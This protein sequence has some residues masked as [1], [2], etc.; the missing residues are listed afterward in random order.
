MSDQRLVL[1]QDTS[2]WLRNFL[3]KV[4]LSIKEHH[5]S[6]TLFM[7]SFYAILVRLV[8]SHE[9]RNTTCLPVFVWLGE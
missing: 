9:F 7:R 5:C 6:C 8:C 2:Q 3:V 4:L 1:I